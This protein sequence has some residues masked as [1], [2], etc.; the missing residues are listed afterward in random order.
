M[1]GAEVKVAGGLTIAGRAR[2][3]MRGRFRFSGDACRRLKARPLID[4]QL[5]AVYRLGILTLAVRG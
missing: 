3:E 1:R 2:G 4:G 5:P